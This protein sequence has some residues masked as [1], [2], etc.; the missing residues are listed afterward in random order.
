[1]F[2]H[3]VGNDRIKTYLA[4]MVQKDTIGNSLLFAGPDGIGKSLFA[5]AFAKMIVCSVDPQGTNL[6]KAESGNHPD[7]HIYKPE[8]KI[9]MHSINSM[10]AFNDEVH[11]PPNEAVKKVFIIHDADRMLPYSANALLKTFEE[12][13][14]DSIIIL[15]SSSPSSLLPTILS[16][17][18][19]IH[20][21]ALEEQEITPIVQKIAN[22]TPEEAKRAALLSRGSIGNALRIVEVGDN[23]VRN[24]ILAMLAAGKFT[25]YTQLA[26]KAREISTIHEEVAQEIEDALKVELMKGYTEKLSAA[27]QQSI[28][29]EIEGAATMKRHSEAL[30]T[31][32]TIL[33]WYR[34]LHLLLA[35][36][37]RRLLF[38]YDHL[39]DLDQAL[40][41]GGLPPLESVQKAIE[42]AR[43]ALER[44]TS[45]NICFESLFLKLGLL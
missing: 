39:D 4:K 36:G 9:G 6:H 41:R 10:R 30:S 28:D 34:D 35:N 14:L 42:S 43:L 40:Q 25:N 27:Q 32:D 5:H 15:L 38:H 17:C 19:T 2:S 33:S 12:P 24:K 21:Q 13:S 26:E 11:F 23:N 16:R 20:F 3:I 8:G 1:M 22:V 31:F 29:K 18:R 44:S 37:N 7:I 45:L